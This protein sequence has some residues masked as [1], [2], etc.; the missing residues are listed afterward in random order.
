[1]Q[2]ESNRIEKFRS[3][4]GVVAKIWGKIVASEQL[5]AS[6][7]MQFFK[8]V[9]TGIGFV[10]GAVMIINGKISLG[11]VVSYLSYLPKFFLNTELLVNTNYGF[12][13]K[14]VEYEKAF[15]YLK[16]DDE[17]E[18]EDNLSEKFQFEK[19]ISFKNIS[20]TY[21]EKQ[22]VTLKNINMSF[23]KNKWIGIIGKSGAGKSTIFS[24]LLS[25]YYPTNGTISIDDVPINTLKK[26]VIRKNITRVSQDTCFFDGTIKDNL[27]LV[28]E[29]ATDDEI[30]K[31]LELVELGDF[32]NSLEKG[33]YT[34][35]GETG[36]NMSGGERQRMSLAQGLLRDSDIILLDEV[37][38]NIDRISEEKIKRAIRNIIN[39]TGKTIISIFH[40]LEFLE[41]TDFMYV[42]D[43]G[44][45]IDKGLYEKIKK[46]NQL[47][48]SSS[49]NL[50]I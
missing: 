27:S 35:M 13:K 1:M 21:K 42:I 7:A 2:L 38:S 23:E 28:N 22:E 46:R 14:L 44:E 4:D 8:S 41:D 15:E 43:K 18:N 11:I 29:K 3:I 24:L 30:E 49:N 47:F 33:I 36:K 32:I 20:F 25:L 9:F 48:F 50:R 39:I 26:Q 12:K 19:A 10:V 5:V 37:T 17:F 40:S 16:M 31:V 34:E 45:I 6:G